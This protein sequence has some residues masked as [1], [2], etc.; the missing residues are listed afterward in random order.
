MRVQSQDQLADGDAEFFAGNVRVGDQSQRVDSGIG[1]A[2]SVDTQ[3]AG[4]ERF[5]GGFHALLD[6]QPGKLELPACVTGS[7]K[8]DRHPK[9]VVSFARKA[10]AGRIEFFFALPGGKG[11]PQGNRAG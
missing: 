2:A 9:A 3:R 6:G 7:V 11:S 8:G 1:A 10:S 5:Q 4:K